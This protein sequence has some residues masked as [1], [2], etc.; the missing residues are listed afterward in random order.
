MGKVFY[1]MGKSAS[2]KDT[3]YKRLLNECSW[4][5]PIVLY[6]TRPKR[7]GEFHGITYYFVTQKEIDEFR[8]KGKVLEERTYHTVSG[9]W[10]YA[11]IDDGQF[12]LDEESYLAIGTLQSYCAVRNYFG[13]NRVVPLYIEVENGL[14][15]SRA[16]AREREQKKPNYA[17]L[18][19][20]FLADEED[21]S[22]ECLQKS[23]INARYHNEDLERCLYLLKKTVY[24]QE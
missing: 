9:L 2:G 18:C 1:L 3:I 8:K 12:C 22:E 14:R 10:T 21:F 15:L 23:G 24:E 4:L 13:T 11:T 6:T 19:R 16:L 7:E 17:E 20:R 5:H